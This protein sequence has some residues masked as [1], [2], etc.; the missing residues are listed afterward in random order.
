MK[1]QEFFFLQQ[2]VQG[3]DVVIDATLRAGP[4]AVLAILVRN[5]VFEF[6]LTLLHEKYSIRIII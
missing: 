5:E 3:L 1:Y 4:Q 6:R 2:I